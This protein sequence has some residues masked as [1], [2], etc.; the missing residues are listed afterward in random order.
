LAETPGPLRA[1][2]TYQDACHLAHA[3]RVTSAPRRLLAQI[4]GLTLREMHESSVCCGSAGIYN[5]TQPEMAD[6]LGTRKA[7]N[8]IAADA[9]VVTTAN[10][11]C[12]LQMKSHLRKAQSDL[13]V[14]HVIEVLDAAYAAKSKGRG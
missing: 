14:R 7:A 11:G 2:V 3:Q 8:V 4:P 5:L 12:A 6:R 10:P 13:P 1:T 9:D